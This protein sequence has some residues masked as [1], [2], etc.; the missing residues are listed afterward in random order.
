MN[1]DMLANKKAI[2]KSKEKNQP[3][4]R[5][6]P[7]EMKVTYIKKYDVLSIKRDSDGNTVSARILI[8][9]KIKEYTKEELKGVK[10][11]FKLFDAEIDVNGNIISKAMIPIEIVKS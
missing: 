7:S 2:Q 8:H 5:K 3:H 6:S 4:K 10:D 9:G 11:E 1:K